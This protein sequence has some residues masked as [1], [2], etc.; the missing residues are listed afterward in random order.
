MQTPVSGRYW[1]QGCE[2]W[3]VSAD[4]GMGCERWRTHRQAAYVA[5]RDDFPYA[6]RPAPPLAV[7]HR[8]APN[9][10]A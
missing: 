10:A 7:Q 9:V 5:T 3:L 2:T 8:H 4:R 6:V 1:S